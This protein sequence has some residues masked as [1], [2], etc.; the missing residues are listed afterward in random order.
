M[1]NVLFHFDAPPALRAR[2]APLLEGLDVRWCAEHDEDRFAELLTDSEA[3]WH[4]LR[5]ITA[6]DMDRAPRLRLIQKLGVG[7]NT[8]DLDAARARGIAVANMPGV[9]AAAV[10]ESTVALML[11]SLRRLVELDRRTRAGHGWPIDTSLAA[12]VGELGD[13]TVGLIG[14]GNI[15]RRV[16]H[17]LRAFGSTVIHTASHADGEDSYRT[18]DEL[19]AASHVVSVHIPLTDAT[20]GML[21]A[22]QLELMRPGAILVNTARGEIVDES[23][24]VAALRSGRLGAAGLD[25]FHSE[26]LDASSPLIEL[27]NVVVQPHVAWL[28]S[29]TM[30]RCT[31]IAADNARRMARGDDILNA[32]V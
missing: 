5:P 24:L 32:V 15:A 13:C 2:L 20:H 7:V 4:V 11:A 29:G 22:A 21:G 10:A 28:T 23:A 3:L 30:H 27:D 31:A 25:V 12:T 9:N 16:E 14:Y 19:L 1:T 18:L 6:A 8:I 26:P 17:V